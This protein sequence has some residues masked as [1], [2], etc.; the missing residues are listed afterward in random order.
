MQFDLLD[1]TQ[2]SI[3]AAKT[4]PEFK[5]MLQ[6]FNC[7][8][9]PLAPSRHHIVVDRGNP[10]ADVLMIGE[11]PGENE[12]R[13]GKAFVGRSGQLLDAMMHDVEFD[14]NRE[15]L[16]INVVKC[17]PPE[18]RPP[19]QEEVD[20]CHAYL[21][22]QIQL[23]NPQIILLLG[24]TALRHIIPEKK[25]FS[26]GQEAGKFFTH[27]EFPGVRFMV[28]FHPAY[29]LRDPRKKPLMMEH[30]KHFMDQRRLSH[31]K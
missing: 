13:Q 4:Y 20:A 5:R 25:R 22:K 16:I 19:K 28:L 1:K 11:A 7:N 29:I 21:R 30:L 31:E 6:E 10:N 15:S 14:T 26:M 23:V 8:L 27:P 9:C 2:N 24:A 12:D 17:R 3:L 18:N